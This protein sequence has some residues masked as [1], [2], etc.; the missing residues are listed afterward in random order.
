MHGVA[1]RSSGSAI[2]RVRPQSAMHPHARFLRRVRARPV[3]FAV[4]VLACIGCL[5]ANFS[6]DRAFGPWIAAVAVTFSIFLAI[7]ILLTA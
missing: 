6:G 2:G 5:R 1:I 4:C 7:S 3:S